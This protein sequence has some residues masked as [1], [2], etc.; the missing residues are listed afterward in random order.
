M[1]SFYTASGTWSV[2]YATE[3]VENIE[4]LAVLNATANAELTSIALFQSGSIPGALQT[5]E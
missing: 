1:P 5:V 2:V 3:N 4:A